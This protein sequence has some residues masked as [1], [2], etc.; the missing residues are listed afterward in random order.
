MALAT[1]S[2][3]VFTCSPPALAPEV[4]ADA[5]EPLLAAELAEHR[6]A[7]AAAEQDV[8]RAHMNRPPAEALI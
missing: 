3:P 6:R 2:S 5:G 1:F 7:A 8:A 4:R